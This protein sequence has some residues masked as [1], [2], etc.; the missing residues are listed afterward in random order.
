MTEA[1]NITIIG[2]DCAVDPARI[3]IAVGESVNGTVLIEDVQLGALD[4]AARI[5]EL[6]SERESALLALDAPLGW[7]AAMGTALSQHLATDHIAV[8]ANR[9]FRRETDLFIKRAIGKQP[10]DVGADRIAR[11]ALAALALLHNIRARTGLPIPIAWSEKETANVTCIEVY[12]GASLEAHGL[13]S[14]GY[15][16]NKAGHR[17][18][19]VELIRALAPQLK[20]TG[21]ALQVAEF[22]DDALDAALCCLAGSDFLSGSA[23]P[24]ED[25]EAARKEGW[26]WVKQPDG[27][28]NAT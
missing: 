25:T 7:P 10:L 23:F 24:P 12:P 9:L 11:T 3:G 1:R 20:L 13:S 21:S 19:R 14:R 4:P 28:R 18:A 26:I 8:D 16:G 27:R 22:S 6:L 5:A 15:K 17:T 2:V